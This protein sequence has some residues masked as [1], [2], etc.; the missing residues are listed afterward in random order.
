M[1]LVDTIEAVIDLTANVVTVMVSASDDPS[2]LIG[3]DDD[4]R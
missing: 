4:S 2:G 3:F 1:S